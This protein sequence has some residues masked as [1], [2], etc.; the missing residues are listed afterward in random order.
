MN[1]YFFWSSQWSLLHRFHLS[2]G[3]SLVLLSLTSLG[4]VI[5]VLICLLIWDTR[6]RVQFSFQCFFRLFRMSLVW[7]GAGSLELGSRSH[8]FPYF[9]SCLLFF[10]FRGIWYSPPSCTLFFPFFFNKIFQRLAVYDVS[11]GG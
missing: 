9:P 6:F 3:I 7:T 2:I 5:V 4:K 1:F 11:S 8:L 10:V